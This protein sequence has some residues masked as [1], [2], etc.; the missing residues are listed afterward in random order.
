MCVTGGVYHVTRI[1]S[2]FNRGT[3]CSTPSGISLINY[4]YITY[5]LE[6]SFIVFLCHE[7]TC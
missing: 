4:I 3:S 6:K 7:L 5:I 1:L 2:D